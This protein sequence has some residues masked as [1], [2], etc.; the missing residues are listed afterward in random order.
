MRLGLE[1][2]LRPHGRPERS[3]Q[4]LPTPFLGLE[5]F[6]KWF[7]NSFVLVAG[8]QLSEY[9]QYEKLLHYLGAASIWRVVLTAAINSEVN[10]YDHL[11]DYFDQGE[12]DQINRF[13]KGSKEA[14]D[15][16]INIYDES[17]VC[18]AELRAMLYT[19]FRVNSEDEPYH[20][21]TDY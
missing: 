11:H 4:R 8:Q 12:I 20:S 7:H 13:P 18:D 6:Y 9:L 19:L 10:P 17:G 16:M 15:L 2:I 5:E 21:G 3:Q 1:S 14:V